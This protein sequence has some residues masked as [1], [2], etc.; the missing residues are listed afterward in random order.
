MRVEHKGSGDH[1]VRNAILGI[2]FIIAALHFTPTLGATTT[3]QTPSDSTADTA[4]A[5]PSDDDTDNPFATPRHDQL[6]D[7]TVLLHRGWNPNFQ[8]W[9][10][11]L[12]QKQGPQHETTGDFCAKDK[13]DYDSHPDGS[14]YQTKGGWL[15]N[16]IP[17]PDNQSD[18]T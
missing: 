10:L 17:D 4:S 14:H 1:S 7:W 16:L 2:I 9:I 15:D 12:D 5:A 13:S 3:H 11:R 8:C 18:S 6:M